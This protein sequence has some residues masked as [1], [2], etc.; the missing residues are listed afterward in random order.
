MTNS[1][2]TQNITGEIGKAWYTG[3]SGGYTYAGST[4]ADWAFMNTTDC[5]WS[6]S[7]LVQTCFNQVM[8]VLQMVIRILGTGNGES[9]ISIALRCNWYRWFFWT[10]IFMDQQK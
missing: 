4:N 1:G 8:V 5:K 6:N 9:E 2:G 7:I 3:T 10:C